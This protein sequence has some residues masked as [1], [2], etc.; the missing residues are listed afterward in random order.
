MSLI[1]STAS[2]GVVGTGVG[3]GV[4]ADVTLFNG[5]PS[6]AKNASTDGML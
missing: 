5:M 3:V 1:F 2:G 6:A 4:G